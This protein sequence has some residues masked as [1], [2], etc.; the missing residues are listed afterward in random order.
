[1]QGYRFSANAYIFPI[2]Q[3]ISR[4]NILKRNYRIEKTLDQQTEDSNTNRLNQDLFQIQDIRYTIVIVYFQ[5]SYCIT[6]QALCD[7]NRY[8]TSNNNDCKF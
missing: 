3:L 1:M 7:I 5:A 4:I 2:E 8:L 6:F